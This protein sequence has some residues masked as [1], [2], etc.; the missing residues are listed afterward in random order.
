M[1]SLSF[2]GLVGL[3]EETRSFDRRCFEAALRFL[4]AAFPASA[5]P[6]WFEP[7][8]GTGRIAVPLAQS[9]YRVVGADISREMLGALKGRLEGSST[10]LPARADATRLPF[11]DGAFD[12]AV[13]VHLFY[14]VRGWQ[15]AAREILRVVREKGAVILMHTGTGAEIPSINDRYME[16][17]A[18]LGSPVPE[19]GVKSTRE[20]VEYFLSLGCE[21]EWIRNRWRWTERVPVGKAL[22]YVRRRAYSFTV[23]SAEEIHEKAAAI[24]ESEIGARFGAPDATVDVPNQIYLVVLR[25]RQPPAVGRG[26]P[27]V[28][29]AGGI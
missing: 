25:R 11:A 3:Y 13:I 4:S 17:C 10:V 18:S 23:F 1:K 15:R 21:A 28:M 16:I 14:F 12:A 8:V 24:L 6:V 20:A 29:A 22:E 27:A 7:G 5:Y 26:G 2:D 19:L 9:G